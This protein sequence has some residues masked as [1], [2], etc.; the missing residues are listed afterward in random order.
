MLQWDPNCKLFSLGEVQVG[1]YSLLLSLAFA[2]GFFLSVALWRRY[3]CFHAQYLEEDMRDRRALAEDLGCNESEVVLMLNRRL[4]EVEPMR[5]VN[6]LVKFA[7][8]HLDALKVKQL[9][10]RLFFD[11]VFE[12]KVVS[13]KERV[14]KTV[15]AGWGIIALGGLVGGRALYVLMHWSSEFASQPGK[16][17]TFWDGRLVGLGVGMG[18]FLGLFIWARWFKGYFGVGRL[19]DLV[20][21]PV[22]LGYVL[23]RIGNFFNQEYVGRISGVSWAVRFMHPVGAVGGVPRHPIQLYE[24][25]L[26]LVLF[27]LLFCLMIGTGFKIRA[28][29]LGGLYFI[30]A[31][32]VSLMSTFFREG[33]GVYSWLPVVGLGQLLSVLMICFGMV[34]FWRGNELYRVGS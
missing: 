17:F 15:S 24:A 23:V 7:V 33:P 21:F 20:A 12:E 2:L 10:N 14:W 30:G 4:D 3:F 19:Y 9:K 25:G 29:R 8:D 34:L 11:E 26:H 16:M 18:L 13:L 28:G 6:R 1:W 27:V 22:G 31:F 32:G 5:R